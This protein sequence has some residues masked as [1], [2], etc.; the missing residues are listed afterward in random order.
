ME[1][2]KFVSQKPCDKPAKHH[3]NHTR[4]ETPKKIQNCKNTILKKQFCTL[5]Q[6]CHM[7][8]EANAASSLI[9][10]AW[11]VGPCGAF[12]DHVPATAMYGI[13]AFHGNP[14]AH[15]MPCPKGV[16]HSGSIADMPHKFL[17]KSLKKTTQFQLQCGVFIERGVPVPVIRI[18]FGLVRLL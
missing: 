4:H 15:P 5:F 14:P 10:D 12:G 9:V 16:W 6:G 7:T 1:H 3:A 2:H 18:L 13:H 11:Q 17:S 8:V